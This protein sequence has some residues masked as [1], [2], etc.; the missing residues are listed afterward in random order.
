MFDIWK[1]KQNAFGLDLSDISV[2][3]MQFEKTSKSVKILGYADYDL[4]KGVIVNDVIM[5]EQALVNHVQNMFAHMQLGK[6]HGKDIV[7]SIPESKAFVRV[8]QIPKMTVEQAEAAVPFEAEQY[9][10]I[11]SGSGLSGLADY[12]RA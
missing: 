3:V 2:K 12:R 7:A 9:I 4:P 5:N 1:Q 10:P 8:I 6:T 11:P